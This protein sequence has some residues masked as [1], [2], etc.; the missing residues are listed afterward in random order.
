MILLTFNVNISHCNMTSSLCQFTT[1][2]SQSDRLKMPARVVTGV[3]A[4]GSSPFILAGVEHAAEPSTTSLPAQV[5]TKL[6]QRQHTYSAGTAEKETDVYLALLDQLQRK[7][8]A[9]D[10]LPCRIKRAQQN[11][12]QHSEV[13][14]ITLLKYQAITGARELI[15]SCGGHYESNE[16]KN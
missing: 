11:M 12:F 8:C 6:R 1:A 14:L 3:L 9:C 10:I 5:H 15:R 7:V 4:F 16:Y 13:K 2:N